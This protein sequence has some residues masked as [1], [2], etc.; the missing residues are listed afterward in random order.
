[1]QNRPVLRRFIYMIFFILLVMA[2]CTKP[3]GII[4][5]TATTAPKE[6]LTQAP[7][8]TPTPE[9]TKA[10]V[11]EQYE[12]KQR[13]KVCYFPSFTNEN[14]KTEVISVSTEDG[15]YV[16]M[17][18]DKAQADSFINA[19]RTLLHF[20]RENGVAV[21]ELNY[22]ALNFD[23]N[24]SESAKDKAYISLSS[25]ETWQQVLVTLHAQWGDFTDYGY[26]YAMA[27]AIAAQLGWQ[28]DAL[29][30]TE[31]SSMD[32]FF[33]ENTEALHL[34]YPAF[35]KL[36]ATEET[37]RYSKSLSLD[38]FE[39]IDWSDALKKPIETQLDEF[40]VLIHEY[41]GKIG[42]SFSNHGFDYAYRGSYLPLCIQTTYATHIVDHGYSDYYS[43]IY[44]DYFGDYVTIYQTAENMDKEIVEAVRHFGLEERAGNIGFNWLSEYSAMTKFANR[45]V[46]ENHVFMQEVYV[47]TISS[48]LH[49]YYHH[50]EHLLN[51]DSPGTYS[52][53]SQAFCEIGASHSRY[54]LYRLEKLFTQDS[55]LAEL[56]YSF[57]G[58]TYQSGVED[59]FEACDIGCYIYDEFSLAYLDGGFSINSLSYYLIKQFGEDTISNLMLFPDT[60]VEVTGKT[61]DTLK[62]EWKQYI[63]DKYAGKETPKS[64]LK[65]LRETLEQEGAVCG[66]AFLGY[67]EGEYTEV[68]AEWENSG[69]CE[70]YPFL[71]DITEEQAILTD[72]G[73]WFLLVPVADDVKVSVY[74][75]AIDYEDFMLK[76]GK[77]LYSSITGA[78]II[79]R[80]N[81]SDIYPSTIVILEQGDVSVEYSPYLSLKDGEL[82]EG[83]GIYNIGQ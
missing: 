26:V 76:P 65:I 15:S 12:Y 51:P 9:P 57:T 29:E 46:N 18:T 77:E 13:E 59:F 14:E 5:P 45:R 52:W 70:T 55:E 62:E 23:D 37:I 16:C 63:M 3:S 60:V 6:T 80:G 53:Q 34:L 19:Q 61:W 49:E 75:S 11:R 82:A 28:T 78:P 20:L 30:T 58:R 24:F 50:M 42:V 7:T 74:E 2:G 8:S 83:E 32:A 47:T 31:A 41:S 17:T 71:Q 56:F 4:T 81:I 10:P 66:V 36:Y 1:M 64:S 22:V 21:R 54:E 33:C 72:G 27:N 67:L 69:L 35:S 39:N 73:E 44:E 68:L 43:N 79:I 40:E 25:T 38:L 48:Y